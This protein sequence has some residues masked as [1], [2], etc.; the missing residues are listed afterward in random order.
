MCTIW[1]IADPSGTEALVSAV[2]HH[3]QANP[4]PVRVK[5]QGLKEEAGYQLFLN[6]DLKQKHPDKKL[7]YGFGPGESISGAAL[8]QVGFVVP[9]A[10]NGFQAWQIS[11]KMA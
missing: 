11:I 4:A 10:A 5:V 7:P 8:K 9:T 3:V 6:G 1:E 2:Y